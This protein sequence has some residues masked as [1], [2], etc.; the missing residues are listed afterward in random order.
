MRR[1]WSL[2]IVVALISPGLPASAFSPPPG[3]PARQQS[4]QQFGA[5]N[6]TVRTA[7]GDSVPNQKL[8]VRDARAGAIIAE[9]TSN[10]SGGFNIAGLGPGTYVLEA[11]NGSSQ[12]IGLSPS[13]AVTPGVLATTTVTLTGSKMAAAAATGGFSLFGLGTGASI[14][15]LAAAGAASVTGIVVATHNASPSK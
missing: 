7:R 5:V 3:G 6:G 9:A 14:A 8:R 11:I 12:V 10:A 13:V 4:P 1:L 2:T 15:V